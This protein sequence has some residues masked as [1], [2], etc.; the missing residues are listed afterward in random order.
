MKIYKVEFLE[1]T[2]CLRD[3]VTDSKNER[4]FEIP[5]SGFV[6]REDDI[7][8]FKNIGGGFK[9]IECVGELVLK[10]VIDTP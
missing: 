7:E 6:I 3:T 9:R 2:N 8:Y 1:F 10:N 5:K 4:Y